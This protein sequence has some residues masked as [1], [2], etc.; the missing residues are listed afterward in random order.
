MDGRIRERSV[1][2][3][4]TPLRRWLIYGVGV[5]LWTSGVLWLLFHYF[6]M[7]NTE[8]GP[9]PSAFE[10]WWLAIHAG[11][12]FAAVWLMGLLWGVHIVGGWKMRRH[13]VSGS[14]LLA[15]LVWLVASGY[16]LYYLG[17]DQTRA[18]VSLA[19]WTAGLALPLPFLVH[20]L[21]RNR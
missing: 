21:V 11:F 4:L 17:G 2:I 12:G 5:G 14:T 8:F 20:W 1:L 18:L 19:H 6:M 10:P 15:F 13:R 3:R 9:A 7:R 16:L